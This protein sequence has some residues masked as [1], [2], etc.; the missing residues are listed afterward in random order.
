MKTRFLYPLG[1]EDYFFVFLLFF[2]FIARCHK[3][4]SPLGLSP[5]AKSS[6]LLLYDSMLRHG[7]LSK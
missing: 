4:F 2:F 6:Q 7:I 3:Q 5:D 1:L